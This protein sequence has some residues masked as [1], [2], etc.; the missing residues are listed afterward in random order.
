MLLWRHPQD[1]PEFF[2][3]ST[4]TVTNFFRNSR[5]TFYGSPECI[6]YR[7]SFEIRPSKMPQLA[8]VLMSLWA[9]ERPPEIYLCFHS[10]QCFWSTFTFSSSCFVLRTYRKFHLIHI[11]PL[12]SI[13]L[14]A[15]NTGKTSLFNPTEPVQEQFFFATTSRRHNQESL[16]WELMEWSPKKML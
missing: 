7:L 13:T 1:Y 4:S 16:L 15:P 3:K 14:C 11:L 10:P 9:D 6:N 12:R 8:N 2:L 5:K